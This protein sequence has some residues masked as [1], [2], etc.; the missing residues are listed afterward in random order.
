M[1]VFKTESIWDEEI[2]DWVDVYFVNGEEVSSHEFD[3]EM[4]YEVNPEERPQEEPDE[5]C[6]GQCDCID[7][8]LDRYVARIQ[9]INGG[10]PCCIKEVLADF[11]VCVVEHVK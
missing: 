4:H 10:C 2:Q 9:E 6:E 1:R 7:C 11:L 5:E 8:T 3:Q